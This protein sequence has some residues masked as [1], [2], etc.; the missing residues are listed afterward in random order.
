MRHFRNFNELLESSPN[1]AETVALIAKHKNGLEKLLIWKERID[2]L[3]KILNEEEIRNDEVLKILLAEELIKE[4]KLD[5][6]G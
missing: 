1:F 3:A 2:N 6:D 4:Y 5:I